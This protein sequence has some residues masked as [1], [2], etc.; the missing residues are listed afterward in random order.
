MARLYDH[1][2]NCSAKNC[3]IIAHFRRI[4]IWH[5]SIVRYPTDQIWK[6][7]SHF[8]TKWGYRHIGILNLTRHPWYLAAIILIWIINREISVSTLIVNT[9]L[10]IYLIIGTIL[11]EKKLIIEL[12]D[13]YRNYT[14]KVSM[15][16]PAKWI[17]SKLILLK[18]IVSTDP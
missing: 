6:I 7:T 2:S 17:F 5:A 13:H 3:N 1:N 9:V 11:E 4:K 12:G 15:L 16:F 10:T 14:E 8:I 18:N